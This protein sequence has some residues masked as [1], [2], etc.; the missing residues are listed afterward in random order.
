MKRLLALILLATG[1]SFAG[2]TLARQARGVSR[3]SSAEAPAAVA[4]PQRPAEAA[5]P[6]VDK[7]HDRMVSTHLP[8]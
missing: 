8:S 4:N 7:R 3:T 2:A 5:K 1:I 6:K